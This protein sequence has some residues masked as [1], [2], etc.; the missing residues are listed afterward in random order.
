MVWVPRAPARKEEEQLSVVSSAD[1]IS[2]L[3][4][5]A[6]AWRGLGDSVTAGGFMTDSLS[7]LA[8]RFPPTDLI[9]E[10]GAR[11]VRP[12][13]HRQH[14]LWPAY[15]ALRDGGGGC[16]EGQR[17]WLHHGTAGRVQHRYQEESLS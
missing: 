10:P 12:L 1:Q 5:L 2:D 3:R 7:H 17:P 15:C 13:H 16:T 6:S 4:L 8:P 9:G 11:A 14:L